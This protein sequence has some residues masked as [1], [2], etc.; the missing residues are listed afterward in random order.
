M[1]P[2]KSYTILQPYSSAAATVVEAVNLTVSIANKSEYKWA[3]NM[4]EVENSSESCSVLHILKMD[5]STANGLAACTKKKHFSHNFMYVRHQ[6]IM[7]RMSND[8]N[9]NIIQFICEFCRHNHPSSWLINIY[10]QFHLE[11]MLKI[12]YVFKLICSRL[13][14]MTILKLCR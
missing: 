6:L 7:Y 2:S 10:S 13:L 9:G 5:A 1:N 3:N 4:E 14:N 11:M 8:K 12:Y